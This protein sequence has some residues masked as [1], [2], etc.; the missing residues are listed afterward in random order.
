MFT[1]TVAVGIITSMTDNHAFQ[2]GGAA[3]KYIL[4]TGLTGP[5]QVTGPNT[6]RAGV[7]VPQALTGRLRDVPGVSTVLVSHLLIRSGR[8]MTAWSTAVS[9]PACP[10]S[11]PAPQA[12]PSPRSTCSRAVRRPGRTACGSWPAVDVPA[13]RLD[14]LPAS[15]IIVG[16]DGSTAAI[17]TARTMFETAF[18]LQASPATVY[19]TQGEQLLSA[20]QQLADVVIL[21]SLPIAGCSLAV[22]VV[23]GLADRRRPFS[24][25]RLAG[26]PVGLL[27]RVVALESAVPLLAVAIVSA[28][29]GLLVAELFLNSQLGLNLRLPG[30]AYYGFIAGGVLLSLGI[31]AATFPLLARITGRKRPGVNNRGIAALITA[32]PAR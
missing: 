7:T 30:P 3:W 14:S 13:S 28:G 25:L 2:T 11:A 20:W 16:T 29:L 9:S 5:Q 10:R 6:P 21:A 31:I 22:G 19:E 24:L 4:I 8:R 15:G 17:E 12:P 1:A 18:P 32:T 27:A 26:T 23:A